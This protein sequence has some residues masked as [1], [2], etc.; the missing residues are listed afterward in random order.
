MNRIKF[1]QGYWELSP[2]CNSFK[3]Y[4][5]QVLVSRMFY[6]YVLGMDNEVKM[7]HPYQIAEAITDKKAVEAYKKALFD[8]VHDL[9]ASDWDKVCKHLNLKHENSHV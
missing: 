5:T 2:S 7:L 8:L 9:S 4:D 3:E 1:M 6:T